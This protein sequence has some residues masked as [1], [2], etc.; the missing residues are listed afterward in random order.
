MP[1]PTPGEWPIAS[2]NGVAKVG[3]ARGMAGKGE[4]RVRPPALKD[5]KRVF[6]SSKNL[7]PSLGKTAPT[8]QQNRLRTSR[9]GL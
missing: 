3:H 1:P 5:S 2:S 6:R 8:I 9:D 4:E 7:H